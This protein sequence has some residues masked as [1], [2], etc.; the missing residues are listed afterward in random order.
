MIAL[1]PLL[2]ASLAGEKCE[3]LPDTNCQQHDLR[4]AGSVS[5]GAACCALCHAEP[6]CR[7]WTWNRDEGNHGCWLKPVSYTHLPSPRDRG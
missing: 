2:S 4:N 6:A 7:A 1:L 3:P 5:D